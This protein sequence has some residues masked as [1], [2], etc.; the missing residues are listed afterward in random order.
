MKNLGIYI[1]LCIIFFFTDII[2]SQNYEIQKTGKVIVKVEK[3]R[4]DK[5]IVRSHIYNIPSTFPRET[6]K[7]LKKAAVKI[8]DKSATITF[9][10]LP[11]GTY[12]VDIHHDENND[13]NMNRSFLGYP[14]EGF[15]LS[16]NP[17]LSL[18]VPN[19]DQCKFTL[20]DTVKI[21]TI[22]VKYLP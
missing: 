22:Y 21:I 18:S 2:F 19:F 1:V 14:K 10:N 20:N 3:L 5:G 16:N 15:G 8:K 4:N 6:E 11:Y 12:A 7:A 9:D 17:K 13:G